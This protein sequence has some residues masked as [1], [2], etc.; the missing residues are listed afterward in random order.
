M[1][2]GLELLTPAEM[3][4]ADR[5]AMRTVPGAVLMENAGR[6]V[7]LEI[8]RRWTRRPVAVA[9]GPG[10]NGGDGLV[11][12]RLLAAAGWPVRVGLLGD[13]ARLEGD[14][15]HHAALW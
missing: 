5:C 1:S 4:E 2:A 10:N 9:C 14:A 13:R 8:L 12:A 6:A 7:A 11:V 15:A 3:A